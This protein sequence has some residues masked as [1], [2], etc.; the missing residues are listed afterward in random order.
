MS[1]VLQIWFSVIELLAITL[2]GVF[3]VVYGIAS[4]CMPDTET[5]GVLTLVVDISNPSMNWWRL[6]YLV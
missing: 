2:S 1:I 5:A 4:L 3:I 6:T